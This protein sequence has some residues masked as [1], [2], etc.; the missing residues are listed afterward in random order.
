MTQCFNTNSGNG[1][2]LG[3]T[4][5]LYSVGSGGGIPDDEIAH[6]N[7][8]STDLVERRGIFL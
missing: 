2:G 4:M 1:G 8:M 7:N 6:W 3:N 5:G